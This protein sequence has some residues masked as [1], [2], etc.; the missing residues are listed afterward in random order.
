MYEKSTLYFYLNT[1]LA[2]TPVLEPVLLLVIEYYFSNVTVLVLKYN[3]SALFPPL[4]P[5]YLSIHSSQQE[6]KMGIYLS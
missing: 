6:I 3:F 1:F 4:V 5:C 2:V